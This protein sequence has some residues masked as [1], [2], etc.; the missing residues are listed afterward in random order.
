MLLQVPHKEALNILQT[1]NKEVLKHVQDFN[2]S[3]PLL[4]L[5]LPNPIE[6]NTQSFRLPYLNRNNRRSRTL[7]F[8]VTVA[9]EKQVEQTTNHFY[10]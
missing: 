8:Y 6:K 7:I 10:P 2:S 4:A 9:D 5:A 3:F 1:I